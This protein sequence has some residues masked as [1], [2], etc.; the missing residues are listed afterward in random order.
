MA[1][2][3]AALAPPRHEGERRRLRARR[4][5]PTPA[6][7]A[8]ACWP[9]RQACG[10]ARAEATSMV[11]ESMTSVPGAAAS[12]DA[13][14]PDRQRVLA[15]RQHGHDGI[16]TAGR[17]C[18]RCS[19]FHASGRGLLDVGG[20]EV[21]ALHLMALLDEVAG[22]GQ[23]HV[24]EPDE[25]DGGHVALLPS[26]LPLPILKEKGDSL[27]PGTGPG[28]ACASRRRPADPAPQKPFVHPMRG[29]SGGAR[30]CRMGSTAD[31][32]MAP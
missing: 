10:R 20:H 32:E 7:R 26:A 13:A 29:D 24:A 14:A 22:H 27:L 2:S 19:L 31:D 9:R 18:R 21:E 3:N 12:Q 23:P 5:P 17:I 15:G 16:D 8:T 25:A 1:L 4:R 11:E 6:H 28:A 30:P